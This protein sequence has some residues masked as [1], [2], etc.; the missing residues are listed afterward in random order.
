[1][2]QYGFF[3]LC[4]PVNPANPFT[5]TPKEILQMYS[6]KL[7][8][9]L[10]VKKLDN[11]YAGSVLFRIS[12][13]NFFFHSDKSIHL[14]ETYFSSTRDY[15]ESR[16]CAKVAFMLPHGRAGSFHFLEYQIALSTGCDLQV[17]LNLL[18]GTVQ[19]G[20][21]KLTRFSVR[22]RIQPLLH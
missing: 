14:Q 9:D 22:A 18:E 17:F 19:Q 20:V 15:N 13:S 5:S 11:R 7:G 4:T 12:N 16:K 3:A 1:M 6:C 8:L 21:Y 10:S 2:K